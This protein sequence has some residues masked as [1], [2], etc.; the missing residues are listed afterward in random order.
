MCSVELGEGRSVE[1]HHVE[2]VD[3]SLV[4]EDQEGGE[5]FVVWSERESPYF[6]VGVLLVDGIA[7]PR[8]DFQ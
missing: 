1:P 4:L 2:Y 6:A 8:V 7:G 3:P 5:A